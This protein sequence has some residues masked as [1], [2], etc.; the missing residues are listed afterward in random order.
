MLKKYLV[1]TLLLLSVSFS[2]QEA[3]AEKASAECF[4]WKVTSPLSTMY[5]LGSVHVANKSIYPLHREIEKAFKASDALVVEADTVNLDE[6]YVQ[7]LTLAKSIYSDGTTL[8]AHVSRPTFD[9]TASE[10]RAMG[11]SMLQ[12][13]LYKPWFVALAITNL[14]LTEL[15]LDQKWGIDTYFLKKAMPEKDIIELEG[16]PA[17]I[18]FFDSF[19]DREQDL[20]LLYTLID[21]DSLETTVDKLIGAWKSADLSTIEY[22]LTN[23]LK[24]YPELMAIYEKVIYERSHAMLY[25]LEEMLKFEKT[26]FVII[27]LAHLIEDKG[28]ISQLKKKGYNVDQF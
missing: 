17:Q 21:C 2:A 9:R 28:I 18:N 19:T 6:Q 20:F 4:L 7:S 25:K 24:L 15:G 23:D 16:I 27:G 3:R 22:L 26:N 12:F 14:K 11:L 13:D 10:L 5:I 8:S 1:L